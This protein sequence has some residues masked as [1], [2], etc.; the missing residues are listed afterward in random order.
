MTFHS[1]L[2]PIDRLVS[3]RHSAKVSS[4]ICQ[5]EPIQ[6]SRHPPLI[7]TTLFGVWIY[8]DCASLHLLLL[9]S[10]PILSS[11]FSP[12]SLLPPPFAIHS[13]HSPFR[14]FVMSSAFGSTAAPTLTG[15]DPSNQRL[16]T[17]LS[18]TLSKVLRHTAVSLGLKIDSQGYVD[19]HELL[20]HPTFQRL[21]PQ[22]TPNLIQ[23]VVRSCPKQRFHLLKPNEASDQYGNWRIRANQGHNAKLAQKL[24]ADS[25]LT[26]ITLSSTSIP[27]ICIHGTTLSAW[28]L[29]QSSGG[30]HPM[31][32]THIH[33][34]SE[35][36]GSEKMISG[37]RRDSAILIYLDLTQVLTW[38]R[39]HQPHVTI[40]FYQS[41]NSV[42][43]TD[44]IQ[45]YNHRLP[46]FLFSHVEQVVRHKSGPMKRIPVDW[47]KPTEEEWSDKFYPNNSLTKSK[48][49]SSSS[50]PLSSTDS[51]PTFAPAIA[52]VARPSAWGPP[53]TSRPPPGWKVPDHLQYILKGEQPPNT[54][55]S[56][57]SSSSSTTSSD[58]SKP[59]FAVPSPQPFRYLAV[60]DFE[61]TCDDNSNG[62]P[63]FSPN[64]VIEW[65]IVLIDTQTGET[66]DEF[67]TYITPQVNPQLTEFCTELTGITQSMVAQSNGA[68]TFEEAWKMVQQ[69]LD[70]HHLIPSQP[71]SSLSSSSSSSS[72]S[73]TVPFSF[74]CCGDWDL[75]TMLPQQ[76]RLTF[77]SPTA[78]LPEHFH[79]WINIKK[80]FTHFYPPS[81]K[82]DKPVRGM[83]DMLEKLKLPLIGRHHS[84]IDDARNIAAICK[85]MI[86]DGC[87]IG[88]TCQN[89]KDV[90]QL[91]PKATPSSSSSSTPTP[92]APYFSASSEP[93]PLAIALAHK[94]QNQ[95]QK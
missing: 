7:S 45:Q 71:A 78:D 75:K 87:P 4:E 28:D 24:D 35:A 49:S 41:A 16:R 62:Q 89:R 37:M 55:V 6:P 68:R 92:S 58:V 30:L 65:P 61:A 76:F 66:V 50:R 29:I 11:L 91:Q 81:H 8:R 54:P 83:T 14:R 94:R 38:A 43:L 57:S 12:S 60:M 59:L 18:H 74:V 23:E 47:K 2:I 52:Y 53:P 20:T 9:P 46:T 72:S 73:S 34:A 40:N 3:Y 93:T 17:Q 88:Y 67:H 82:R 63:R 80:S 13:L 95:H 22:V 79:S 26:P 86:Q 1:R 44:G 64:E 48:S 42:I 31:D 77:D 15:V 36:F 85:K 70:K 69:F 33:F 10:F 56:S 5:S 84:G 19:L 39:D 21:G 25:L 51:T 32:R 27:P 90:K